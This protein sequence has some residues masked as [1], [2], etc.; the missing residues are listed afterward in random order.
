[1][2]AADAQ[3]DVIFTANTGHEL[4]H[5]GLD[6][7][8]RGKPGLI[9]Q[10]HVW[11]HLGANFAAKHGSGVR[12]QY[13]DEEARASLAPFLEASGLVP[14]AVDPGRPASAG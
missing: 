9:A 14:A 8:L 2:K 11:V 12:L 10:A 5:T 13:S 6:Y 3:R 7:F 1:M 4:G